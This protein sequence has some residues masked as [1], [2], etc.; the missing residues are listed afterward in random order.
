MKKLYIFV[1]FSISCCC[2][3]GFVQAADMLS[4]E[5]LLFMEVPIVITAAKQE[6]SIYDAPA[7]MTVI[8]AEEIRKMGAK[9]LIDVLRTVPGFNIIQDTNEKLTVIHGVY[10]STN[11][12][13]L[14]LRDGHRL[15]D[16]MFYSTEYD[17]SLTLANVKRIE[18][19]RGPGSTLYGSAAMCGVVNVIT[20]N[21]ADIK[22]TEVS[23]GVGNYGQQTADFVFG[24]A[25]GEAND[26]SIY[27]SFYGSEGEK[28]FQPISRDVSSIP[29]EGW[30][31]GD[32]YP[33]NY[34]VGVK[35][36]DGFVTFEASLRR[37]EYIPP[38][39]NGGSLY[40]RDTIS[41]DVEQVFTWAYMDLLYER[42][43]GDDAV[44]KIR[45]FLDYEYWDSW[46]LLSSPREYPPYGKLLWME[47]DSLG[48]GG[49]YSYQWPLH[50]GN[51]LAGMKIEQWWLLGSSYTHNINNANVFFQGE[52]LLTQDDGEYYIA[53]YVQI[54]QPLNS[55]IDLSLGVSYDY[56]EIVKESINPRVG[57]II[58]PWEEFYWKLLYAR[59]FMNPSYF[60]RYVTPDAYGYYGGPDLQPEI[61]TTYQTSFS[62]R[63]GDFLSADLHI[64]YN[65]IK[66]LISPVA[67]TSTYD[68]VGKQTMW[69]IEPEFK[70]HINKKTD[71][72]A[73]FTHQKPVKD[74]TSSSLLKDGTINDIPVNTANAGITYQYNEF[75]N[76]NCVANWHGSIKSPSSLDAEY[77]IGPKA[78]YDFN[79]IIDLGKYIKGT[80]MSLK[81]YNI[82]D[83]YDEEGGSVQ[84]PFPRG[85]RKFLVN[86]KR[87]F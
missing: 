47:Y 42:P 60:Y 38:R 33:Q 29:A 10:A 34:D 53:P 27:G 22:K 52:K 86:V 81:I 70:A 6:Q 26:I 17:Y 54:E 40:D 30:Q 2:F 31:Y 56:Y 19:I 8:T 77:K 43:T 73:N 82:F 15:N 44:L 35:L 74:K 45:H 28:L 1:I 20:K 58:N 78:I 63:F 85:G 65:V 3:S 69:G 51:V 61:M 57:L 9:T 13:F 23:V 16:N 66:D 55:K 39:E 4:G 11:Q 64:F 21:G 41:R 5:D 71:I 68:N 84:I 50:E 75:L 46:Q 18:V 24:R 67:I 7:V 72:F 12:K 48:V 62:N 32:R 36:R 25:W 76:L 37:S 87:S 79:A 14:L 83:S 80:E 59:A 49:D